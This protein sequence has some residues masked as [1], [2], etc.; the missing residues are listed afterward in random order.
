MDLKSLVLIFWP[1]LYLDRVCCA[2]ILMV[3]L[4]RAKSHFRFIKPLA[5][6]IIKRGHNLTLITPFHLSDQFQ[7][8]YSL[9]SLKRAYQNMSR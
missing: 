3:Q 6:E 4:A 1:L 5:E 8:N 2:N 7:S 9:I